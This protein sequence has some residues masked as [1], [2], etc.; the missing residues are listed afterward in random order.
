MKIYKANLLRLLF[1]ILVLA[2][3]QAKA[4][5]SVDGEKRGQKITSF[6]IFG[7]EKIKIDELKD[8]VSTIKDLFQKDTL[9]L[10][11]GEIFYP[12]EVEYVFGTKFTGAKSFSARAP[13]G[14]D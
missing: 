2:S 9:E 13:G 8:K 3:F 11:N 14:H 12:E 4:M 6:Q 1:L 7:G 5:I 10:K